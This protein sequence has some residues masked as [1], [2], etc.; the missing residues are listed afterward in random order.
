MKP[1]YISFLLLSASVLCFEIVGTRIASVVFVSDYAYIIVSLAI[2]GLGAGGIAWHFMASPGKR[3]TGGVHRLFLYLGISFCAFIVAVTSFAVTSPV[4]FFPLLIAPFFLG[5]MIYARLYAATGAGFTLYA[6]DLIGAVI[7]SVASV[8]VISLLGASNAVLLLALVAWGA[9]ALRLSLR[10]SV[11]AARAV[12]VGLAVAAGVLFYNGAHDFLGPIA[13][14]RYADKD[15]Y[16][17]YPDPT[18]RS[19]VVDS[20]WSIYGRADLL[21]YSHQDMVRQMFIDGAAGT[22][23]YRFNGDLQHTNSNLQVLLLHHSNAIP[24]VCMGD[25]EKRSMLVIGPGGGKEIL[26]G[27]FGGV[28]FIGEAVTSAESRLSFQG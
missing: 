9:W 14:G 22:Q 25:G 4:V 19:H 13:I 11:F 3:P 10:G 28:S 1:T 5:G 18:I 16:Y 6:T 15:I 21:A 26:I 23:V 24:F 27:L 12:A 7:G 17:V 2:L 20:R 8:G